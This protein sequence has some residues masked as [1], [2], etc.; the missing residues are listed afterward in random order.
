MQESKNGSRVLPG[1]VMLV[2]CGLV[3]AGCS[4]SGSKPST[5]AGSSPAQPASA[6]PVPAQAS[7]PATTFVASGPLVVENQVD[8]AARREGV[9]AQLLADVGTPVRAGQVLGR[10]DDRQ[11]LADMDMARARIAQI[12]ANVENWE[13]E[14]KVLEADRERA[15]KMWEAQLIT[16][17]DLDHARFKLVADQFELQREREALKSV[18]AQARSIE[19]ELEKTRIV[20][21]FNG[22]VARRYVRVGQKVALGD[23]LFWVTA[24]A[25]LRVKVALPEQFVSKVRSGTEV[26]VTPAYSPESKYTARV[27]R[28]S[29]VVDPSSGTI[30]VLAELEGAVDALKPG[31]TVN[32]L[33]D[34]GP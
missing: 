2:A 1:V 11:L 14:V 32:V 6:A 33:F 7:P 27:L 24:V 15:E 28:V 25:P 19:L 16:K 29:P 30:E 18:T 20:A 9:V 10:L 8:V 23:R 34:A 13:A 4:S 26:T 21:P 22:V 3:L 17:Q 12:Q 5:P 31:M